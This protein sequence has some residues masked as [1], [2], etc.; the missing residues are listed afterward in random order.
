MLRGIIGARPHDLPQSRED[1]SG[2]RGTIKGRER[3]KLGRV[4]P[5]K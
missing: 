4:F 1:R 5:T 3:F 2:Q